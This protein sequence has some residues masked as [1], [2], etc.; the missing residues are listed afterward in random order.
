MNGRKNPDDGVQQLPRVDQ[1]SG[2]QGSRQS[3]RGQNA[4]QAAPDRVF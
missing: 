2:N 1:P 3:G 4:A